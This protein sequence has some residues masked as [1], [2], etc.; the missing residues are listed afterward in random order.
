MKR[1]KKYIFLI[2]LIVAGGFLCI[3]GYTLAKYVSSSIWDYYLK[4]KG[5][6]FSSD[7]LGSSIVKNADNM[8]D[9]GSVHFNIKNNL[10]EMVMTDY[11]IDYRIV[12][13]IEGDASTHAECHMNGTS[14]NT[15]D[16]VLSSFQACSNPTDDNVDVSSLNK[17]DCELGGY[18]WE[19][20]VAAK[21]LYFDV[22][23]ND[24]NYELKDIVVNVTATSLAPYS[25]TLS[26]Q[27]ALH[28]SNIGVADVRMDYKNY[29][30][31]DRLTISNSYSSTK[32][33]SITWDSSKLMINADSSEFSSYG[34]DANGYVNEIKININAKSSL[35]YI[36]YGRDFSTTYNVSEFQIMET[37]GC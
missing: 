24:S 4:S 25:K 28:K 12:C 11:D 18:D 20:Q 29:T 14:S 9:G 17:T 8:W 21:E 5:F 23:L 16:G 31:Y 7:Y 3:C 35:S 27:F 19:N 37:T 26:C 1:F 10:N 30:G 22:V 33:I 15:Q 13:T 2:L 34:V 32:C 6:H 36:F